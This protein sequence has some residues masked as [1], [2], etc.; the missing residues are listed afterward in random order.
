[1]RVGEIHQFLADKLR[2]DV[3]PTVW[4]IEGVVDSDL[5]ISGIVVLNCFLEMDLHR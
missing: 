5:S 1:M 4:P 3:G 2:E